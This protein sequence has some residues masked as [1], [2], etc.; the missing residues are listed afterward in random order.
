MMV[1]PEPGLGQR[2]ETVHRA[3]LSAIARELHYNGAMTRTRLVARTGL[4]RSAIRT[5]IGEFLSAGL[6]SEERSAPIGTPG[7]PSRVVRPNHQR[8]VALGLE[9]AVDSLAVALVGFGGLVHHLV[10]VD[11]PRSHLA[12]KQ[13][14][15]DLRQLTNDALGHAPAGA[16]LIGAGAAVVGVVRRGDGLVRMAP[17]LGWIDAPLGAQLD[18]DLGLG[19]PISVANEADLGALAEH[20]RGAAVGTDDFLYLSG[21]VGVGGGLILGGRPMTGA[22]GYGGEV[23]HMPVNPDGAPC[24]CGAVGCWETEIG[25]EALLR[26][27]GYLEPGGRHAVDAVLRQ[28]GTGAPAAVAAVED[29]GRW[30]GIGLAGLVNA[31]NP[32][33]VVAGGLFHRLYPLVATNVAAELDRRTLPASRSM[34]R[35]VPA[36]LGVDAPLLGAAEMAFEPL[37]ADPGPWLHGSGV[38][39]TAASA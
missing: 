10:R 13:I 14:V 26:R 12:L 8:I 15:S 36:E 23:G 39:A 5:L 4:T 25:E 11:R 34:M 18:M 19:V 20:R 3:N 9:I 17:N 38:L 24:G 32:E 1:V 33:L 30:L 7:R 2:S 37:L 28:A 27:A 21:E 6:V 35:L 16:D 22:A 31:F 29:T